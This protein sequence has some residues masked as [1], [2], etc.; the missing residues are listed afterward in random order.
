MS[1]K[2]R[3]PSFKCNSMVNENQQCSR[4]V[5]CERVEDAYCHAHLMDN[6]N[7]RRLSDDENTLIED[8]RKF[9]GN[10]LINQLKKSLNEIIVMNFSL[11]LSLDDDNDDDIVDSTS[12][13]N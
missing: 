4:L 13:I 8:I 6:P 5:K 10:N 9:G 2:R 1:S 11:K 12:Y 3:I 7:I